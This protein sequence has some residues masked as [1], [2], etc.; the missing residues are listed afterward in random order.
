MPRLWRRGSWPAWQRRHGLARAAGARRLAGP[1][2]C[3]ARGPG[4]SRGPRRGADGGPPWRR[5]RRRLAAGTGQQLDQL[6]EVEQVEQLG[7]QVIAVVP[8]PAVGGGVRAEDCVP[9][10]RTRLLVLQPTPFCNMACSYCY[11]PARDKRSRMPLATVRQA[12]RRLADDGLA[13]D[14]LTVVWHAGEPLVLPPGYYA[15]AFEAIAAALPGVAVTHAMQ[16]NATLISDAW[17]RFFVQHGVAVGVSVDGPPALHDACRRTRRG[18]GTSAR[19]QAGLARLRAPDVPLVPPVTPLPLRGVRIYIESHQNE[20]TLWD[21]L[22]D[23]IRR[24]WDE[25]CRLMAPGQKPPLS[26]RARALPVDRLDAHP[27]LD[28][29][30][31]V[32]LLWGRKTSEALVAQIN[33]VENKMTPGRDAAPGI[34]AYLMPPQQSAEP[35]PAWGW[36]VLRFNA[37]TEDAI[38]V[39]SEEAD[40]LERF[41]KKI[42][43]RRQQLDAA[44]GTP[45]PPPAAMPACACRA[46]PT[47][48]CAPSS[49]SSRRCCSGVRARCSK[50]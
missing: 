13:G 45:R 50:S 27:P 34:V 33:K 21:P 23:Q 31:G 14:A 20:L 1:R 49:T 25:V 19:V 6:A 26:L 5:C 35:V 38:D 39:V 30:D 15:A 18:G 12:A 37:A 22:G 28:D 32:V 42:F 24:K 48:G 10:L 16:T 9:R 2:R 43:R 44:A 3:R 17:C 41:L 47:R 29:A 40:Q 36:Q 11:L 8:G 46:S 4:P 7:Q